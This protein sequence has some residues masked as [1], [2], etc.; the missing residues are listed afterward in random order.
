MKATKF[1][2]NK[3]EVEGEGLDSEYFAMESVNLEDIIVIS[4]IDETGE[5]HQ[6]HYDTCDVEFYFKKNIWIKII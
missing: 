3:K 2:L 4:W 5:Y 1:K 6:K